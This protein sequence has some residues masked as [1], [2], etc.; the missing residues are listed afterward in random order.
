M[1]ENGFIDYYE[2]LQLNSNAGS[3]TIERV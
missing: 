1:S 3:D 2:L